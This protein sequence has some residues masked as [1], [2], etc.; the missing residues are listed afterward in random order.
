M[1]EKKTALEAAVD[2]I[3]KHCVSTAELR[4]RLRAKKTEPPSE[5]FWNP[6][7][8]GYF[9]PERVYSIAK[10]EEAILK[11]KQWGALRDDYLAEEIA[12]SCRL[13][14]YGPARIRI[15]LKKRGI[16][17]D[18]IELVMSRKPEDGNVVSGESGS[19]ASE[20]Q[21]S[22]ADYAFALLQRIATQFCREPDPS[23][24]RAK[25]VRRLL[26]RGFSYEDANKAMDRWM[27]E[28]EKGADR[29]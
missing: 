8:P 24:R 14:G 21:P 10:V 7:D 19:G 29:D 16:P 13:R 9:I 1:Y 27:H 12:K 3:V 2:I 17:E 4:T 23:K 25:A 26:K 28:E 22:D 6:S 5:K 11:L 15:A 20:V 18:V